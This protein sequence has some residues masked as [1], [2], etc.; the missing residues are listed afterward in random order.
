MS[1]MKFDGEKPRMDLVIRGF[2]RALLEVGKIATFGCRKY[3]EDSW[4][5]VPNALKRYEAALTRHELAQH[6]EGEYDL[7]SG[8]LHKAHLAWNALATLELLLI[9]MEKNNEN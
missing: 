7:E 4:L 1:D 2:P 6:H 5:T 8:L 3:A 9:T